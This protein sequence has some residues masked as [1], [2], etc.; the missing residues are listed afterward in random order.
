MFLGEQGG[1]KGKIGGM[2]R[3]TGEKEQ[4]KIEKRK[5]RRNDGIK[6]NWAKRKPLLSLLEKKKEI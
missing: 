1:L 6:A 2:E 3:I 5:G 4:T